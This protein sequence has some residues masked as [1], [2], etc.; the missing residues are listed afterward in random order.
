[1]KNSNNFLSEV[2]ADGWKNN[3]KNLKM[4]IWVYIIMLLVSGVAALFFANT[5]IKA[6]GMSMSL[7]TLMQN[8]DFM[9]FS[10]FWREKGSTFSNIWLK[11]LL[12]SQVFVFIYSYLSGGIISQFSNKTKAF[13]FSNFLKNANKYFFRFL[14]LLFYQGLMLFCLFLVAGVFYFVFVLLA[15]GSTEKGY[16]FWLLPPTALL[17]SFFIFAITVIIYSKIFLVKNE[18]LGLNEAFWRAFQYVYKHP[19]SIALFLLSLIPVTLIWILYLVIEHYSG[20]TSLATLVFI[21]ILQQLYIFIKILFKNLNYCMAIEFFDFAPITIQSKK[22][23]LLAKQSSIQNDLPPTQISN[24]EE[25]DENETL[26][27]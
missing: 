13:S 26:E 17:L 21:A 4:H 22:E 8:F 5:L 15:E 1:M 19:K 3:L 10:D 12:L 14:G 27:N 25:T 11:T 16:F 2:I 6:R 23:Q 24:S 7:D 9:I 18:M 20:I